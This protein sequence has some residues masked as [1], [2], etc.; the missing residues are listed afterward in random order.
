[1]GGYADLRFG[2]VVFF[3]VRISVGFALEDFDA[4]FFFAEDVP[5][6][7]FFSAAFF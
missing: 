1:V 2:P 5:A 6:E 4:I 7:A 3:S